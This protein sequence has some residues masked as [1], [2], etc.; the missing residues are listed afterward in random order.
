MVSKRDL[1]ILEL[2]NKSLRDKISS[3]R[4]DPGEFPFHGCGDNSCVLI[5]PQGMGTNGGCRCDERALRRGVL[6]LRRKI[7]FQAL[8]IQDLKRELALAESKIVELEVTK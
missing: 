8:S 3:L 2:Q 4:I 5:Q 1:E 7:E 6:W